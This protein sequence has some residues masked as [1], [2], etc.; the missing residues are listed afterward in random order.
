MSQYIP[1]DL[2]NG[3]LMAIVRN[4]V[5]VLYF[6]TVHDSTTGYPSSSSFVKTHIQHVYIYNK[7]QYNV[8]NT[9]RALSGAALNVALL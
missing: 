1:S 7:Y 5:H 2:S 4:G 8:R 3:T 9:E 6:A